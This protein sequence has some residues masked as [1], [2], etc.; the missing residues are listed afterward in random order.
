MLETAL[1]S[2]YSGTYDLVAVQ[3][4]PDAEQHRRIRASL[5]G[6][7]GLWGSLF[8]DTTSALDNAIW[9]RPTAVKTS[10]GFALGI[11]PK[12]QYGRLLHDP[13][14]AVHPPVV[15]HYLAGD[16]DFTLINVHHFYANGKTERAA[17]EFSRVLDYLA[18]YFNQPGHDPDV[19]ICGDF[20]IPSA[21]SGDMAGGMTLDGLLEADARFTDGERRFVVLGHEKTE[22]QTHGEA[23]RNTDHCLCSID[24]LEELI[25]V[26]RVSPT[27]LTDH[28]A[29]PAQWLTSDHFPIAAF[30]RTHG[31]G[32]QRDESILIPAP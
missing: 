10:G 15:G 19:L 26:K 22:R 4:V 16:F 5:P 7:A 9:H 25:Q 11:P 3:G 32:V 28:P 17:S 29:D 30:F 21:L 18:W 27:L 2:I 31:D 8:F 6:G 24:A 13:N 1:R 23:F 14:Q 12:S 20:G